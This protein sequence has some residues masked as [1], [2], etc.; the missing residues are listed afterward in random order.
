MRRDAN[1]KATRTYA[2]W[3]NMKRRVIDVNKNYVKNNIT[4]CERW[5]VFDNFLLDMGECPENYTLDRI[6]TLGNYEKHNCRWADNETQANNRTNTIYVQYQ[7]VRQ[8][9]KLLCRKM[10][11]SYTNAVRRYHRGNS[12]DI[13]LGKPDDFKQKILWG[14]ELI[15]FSQAEKI[16]GIR[17]AT[18]QNRVNLYGWSVEKAM[19]TPV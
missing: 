5:Q 3:K 16:T 8:P 18:L 1:G 15:S 17:K 12:I 13:I 9:L 4:V 11:V 6:D 19:T 10:N 7:G 2:A 14:G